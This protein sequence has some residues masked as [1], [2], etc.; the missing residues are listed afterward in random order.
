MLETAELKY[1]DKVLVL[2]NHEFLN[3]LKGFPVENIIYATDSTWNKLFVENVYKIKAIL[4]EDVKKIS[5]NLENM[6]FDLIISNPPY[7]NG[8]DLKILN[9]VYELGTK[10]CFVHPST[11]LHDNKMKSKLFTSTRELVKKHFI[12]Y[13][14]IESVNTIFG[15]TLSFADI[16][17]TLIDK[18][19]NGMCDAIY[20]IDIHG[21]SLEYSQLKDKFINYKEF[22]LSN[23]VHSSNTAN[24]VTFSGIGRLRNPRY[25]GDPTNGTYC[26]LPKTIEHEWM[27]KN[28][29]KYIQFV[30]NTEK[31]MVS[32]KNFLK[33]K[34]VRFALSIFKVNQH[35]DSGELGAVPYMPTYEHEWSDE[36]V[37]KELGLTDEELTWAINWIPDYYPEDKEK[38][39]AYEI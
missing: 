4:I 25:N 19:T 30:F 17:I 9:E 13:E 23:I 14:K 6:K 15:I 21:N 38:Y 8:L 22:L 16:F 12:T 29:N 10:I 20:N 18:Q 27:G 31:E 1:T 11:W 33:L 26:F 28:S 7:N 34:I 2:F 37:A 3:D 35:I 24:K 5:K 32:F 36:M 39:K